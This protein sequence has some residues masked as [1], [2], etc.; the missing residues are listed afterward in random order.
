MAD[1]NL[2]KTPLSQ[3]TKEQI[4]AAMNADDER[5][6]IIRRENDEYMRMRKAPAIQAPMVISDSLAD[7]KNPTDGKIYDSKSAYHRQLKQAG[8]H[9]YEGS[10]GP[11]QKGD[12]DVSKELKQAIQQH[13]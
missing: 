8:C 2:H 10:P 6:R 13:L 9:V 12:H 7:V 3:M 1:V 5:R 11:R 4:A